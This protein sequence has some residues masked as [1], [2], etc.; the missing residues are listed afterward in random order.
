MHLPAVLKRNAVRLL[1]IVAVVLVAGVAV[2]LSSAWT[3]PEPRDGC[4][5]ITDCP[6]FGS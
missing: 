5:E 4:G 2:V 3:G 1:L 6:T